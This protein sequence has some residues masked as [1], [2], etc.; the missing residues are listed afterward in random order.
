VRRAAIAAEVDLVDAPV[1]A[2][3]RLELR[4]YLREQAISQTLHRFGN[5]VGVAS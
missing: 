1:T 3:G 5:L 4:W 2:S